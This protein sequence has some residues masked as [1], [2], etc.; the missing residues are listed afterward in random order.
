MQGMETDHYKAM[1]T[2]QRRWSEEAW[3]AARHI[4]E[5][6]LRLPFVAELSAGTL[7]RERFLFYLEQDALYLDNYSRV[8]AEVASRLPLPAQREAFLRF[9]T[10]GIATERE[11]QEGYLG[12]SHTLP[13]PS[14]T[15]LLYCSY[16]AAQCIEPVEVAASA[17]LPCFWLYQR[18]GEEVLRRSASG[19]PYHRWV[20]TYGDPAF[21]EAARV[22][23]DICDQLAAGATPAMRERM[24]RTFITAAR[25]EY[26][27]W[28]SAYTMEE[29]KI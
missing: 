23:V 11:M 20:A 9:A 24:T 25:M 7:S 17:L 3:E 16:E 12:T 14:P 22:A 27:F 5:A 28:E 2:M 6:I 26:L 1:G 18:V 21:A 10:E 4:Y 13:Q 15:C 29:W 8:L 19:N